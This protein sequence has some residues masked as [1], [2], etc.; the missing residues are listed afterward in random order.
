[1]QQRRTDHV[2]KRGPTSHIHTAAAEETTML[3][4][5][6]VWS[7]LASTEHTQRRCP[8]GA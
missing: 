8:E 3:S 2:H 7:Q 6:V 5:A 1:M 4:V